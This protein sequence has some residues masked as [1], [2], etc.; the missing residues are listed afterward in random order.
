[1]HEAIHLLKGKVGV[2]IY[3]SADSVYDVSQERTKTIS[4]PEKKMP[5]G[6]D[7]ISIEIFI[8]V[9][10]HAEACNSENVPQKNLVL[11]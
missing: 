6:T 8:T 7:T 4:L 10:P 5:R 2:Y 9:L 3:A 1:M 11:I